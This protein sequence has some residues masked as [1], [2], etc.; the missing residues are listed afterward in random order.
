M[1]YYFKGGVSM[2]KIKT[3]DDTYEVAVA[4]EQWVV[5]ANKMIQKSRFELSFAEQR[6]IKYAISLIKPDSHTLS[7]EFN[8]RDYAKICGL[9]SDQGVLYQDTR[10]VLKEISDR[11]WWIEQEDGSE[12]LVRWIVKAKMT[13]RSGKVTLVFDED[14]MPYLLDFRENYTQY[15]LINT[16]AMKSI[17]SVRIY[18]LLISLSWRAKSYK[19]KVW[20]ESLNLDILKKRLN[21]HDLL[22]YNNF[23]AFERRVLK[24][25][26]QEINK[27]TDIEINYTPI[28]QGRKVVDVEF[29]I[30]H[31]DNMEKSLVA[32]HNSKILNV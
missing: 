2:A 4:R 23:A 11:S 14:M 9:D 32:Y 7:Y 25:A 30:R 6:I 24:M 17:Y 21:V 13:K 8:I 20:V 3:K 1:I 27:Y 29:Q 19:N 31:R 22:T 16:L 5:Q 10:S 28:K 15:Q 12:V 26:Q 18:E